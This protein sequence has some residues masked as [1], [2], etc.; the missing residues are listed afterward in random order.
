MN[1]SREQAYKCQEGDDATSTPLQW[2]GNLLLNS[3]TL[4]S[5]YYR[6]A[7]ALH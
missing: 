1:T 4:P 3:F 6:R 2:T 7:L 5:I